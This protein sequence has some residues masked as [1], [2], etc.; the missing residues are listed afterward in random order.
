MSDNIVFS[1]F[2]KISRTLV[3]LR[4]ILGCPLQTKND[5]FVEFKFVTWMEII[6][7]F[8]VNSMIGICHLYWLFIFLSFD[9]SIERLIEFYHDIYQ[10]YS[11]STLD[12]LATVL[13][14]LVT[15]IKTFS[16]FLFFKKSIKSFN[17]FCQEF[18]ISKSKMVTLSNKN[19]GDCQLKC[20][21]KI[22]HSEKLLMHGQILNLTATTL[23][24]IW[25][26]IVTNNTN[27]NTK[28]GIVKKC[29]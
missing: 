26:Y 9:G 3:I 13:W 1:P 14:I 19:I 2:Y 12:Q 21:K 29:Q 24:T 17:T 28:N 8:I 7:L 23:F 11:T 10:Y 15:W 27:S 18:C 25:Y 4:W 16:Y 6:R 20:W 22:T 5:S